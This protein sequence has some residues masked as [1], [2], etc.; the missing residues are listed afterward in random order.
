MTTQTTSNKPTHTASIK[1]LDGS[2]TRF[3]RV[4]VAWANEDG[5]ICF[6]PY[7]TQIIHGNIYIN[8]VKENDE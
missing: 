3:E 4:G 1:I 8:P 5:K 2:Q 7:G 6:K